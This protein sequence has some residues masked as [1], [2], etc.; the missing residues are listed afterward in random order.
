MN[1]PDRRTQ[2]A[3]RAARPGGMAKL[4]A[5]RDRLESD[6]AGIVAKMAEWQEIHGKLQAALDAQDAALA[7]VAAVLG[8]LKA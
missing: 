2:I 7:D 8:E 6:R 1:Q 5:L 3:E 4:R